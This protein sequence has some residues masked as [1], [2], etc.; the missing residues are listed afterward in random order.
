[1]VMNKIVPIL[2]A[3][4]LSISV[5]FTQKKPAQKQVK[6]YNLSTPQITK[7]PAILRE[8]SGISFHAGQLLSQ[9]DE[10]G[11]IFVHNADLSIQKEIKFGK[12]NDYEDI[13]SI[14][15]RIFVLQSNGKIHSFTMPSP[16]QKT[17][18]NYTIHDL[19]LSKGEYEGLASSHVPNQLVVLCKACEVD[20][21]QQQT[22]GYVVQLNNQSQ[23]SIKEH[24]TIPWQK[25]EAKSKP[26]KKD[27]SPSAIAWNK[28]TRQW[29][30][31]SSVNKLLVIT[32]AT[33][34]VQRVYPLH[35]KHFVQ[36]EGIAF[37]NAHN[38]YIASE[39]KGD[40]NGTILTFKMQ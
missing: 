8:V 14:G 37:D 11:S 39:G 27:F 3:S 25:I 12:N 19:P 13:A 10:Q 16:S 26:L 40:D 30:I 7:L 15:S 1:M 29:Y 31:V 38:L 22:S 21:K 9:Q 28:F 32:D 24:F 34:N 35:Y 33:W 5:G 20:K 17:V 23:A 4:I 18:N 2:V 6:G 36:P